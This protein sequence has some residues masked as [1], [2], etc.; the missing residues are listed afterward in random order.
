MEVMT[1]YY[2]PAAEDFLAS[3]YY[4]NEAVVAFSDTDY[5]V[6][7]PDT[8]II[9]ADDFDIVSTVSEMLIIGSSGI[10]AELKFTSAGVSDW[11]V[12]NEL[13]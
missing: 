2:T 10:S 11:A 3:K 5:I 9:E 1:A 4:Y 8:E 13:T 7:E 6:F 12:P